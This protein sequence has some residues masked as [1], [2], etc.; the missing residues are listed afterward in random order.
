MSAIYGD[1][2]LPTGWTVEDATRDYLENYLKVKGTKL[3]QPKTAY[4]LPKTAIDPATP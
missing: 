2:G 4:Q 1:S 3:E